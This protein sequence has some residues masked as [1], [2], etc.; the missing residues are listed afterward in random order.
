M[1]AIKPLFDEP[2]GH[3]CRAIETCRTWSQLETAY[4][5]GT[6]VVLSIGDHI[7]RTE[8]SHAVKAATDYKQDVLRRIKDCFVE[9]R[10]KIEDVPGVEY[11][12]VREIPEHVSVCR[13]CSGTGF[14]TEPAYHTCTTCN[15]TGRVNI[16]TTVRT[17]ITPYRA[18]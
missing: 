14:V 4:K 2:A 16:T 3:I 5:W 10:N 1:K 8:N 18:E 15:G 7:A 17:I 11:I 12:N 13:A 9:Q 6:D